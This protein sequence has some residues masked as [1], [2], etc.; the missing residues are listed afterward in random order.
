[1]PPYYQASGKEVQCVQELDFPGEHFNE[2]KWT[3]MLMIPIVTTS[4]TFV[5]Q[6]AG[7]QEAQ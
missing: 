1:M 2:A 6:V 5:L 3:N 4:G 7:K